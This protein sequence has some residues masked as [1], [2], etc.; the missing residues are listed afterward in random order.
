MAMAALH[1]AIAQL[2]ERQTEDLKVPGSI[3]GLG[4]FRV[5]FARLCPGWFL[6][7]WRGLC[8]AR[9]GV[10]V[11]EILLARRYFGL[12]ALVGWLV[13]VCGCCCDIASLL[14]GYAWRST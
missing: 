13:S 7:L 14:L 5:V 6:L 9:W 1:A 11:L 3:P 8:L 4:S 2:G 12:C 10:H